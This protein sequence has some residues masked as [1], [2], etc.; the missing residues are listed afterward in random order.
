MSVL[1]NIFFFIIAIGVLVTFHEFGHY[2][3]ARKS[4]VK[5]L[6]FSIGFGR[7]LISWTRTTK[8]GDEIEFVIAAIPLGGYVRM[9]DE[10]EG[11][12]DE[13]DK[14][15][16]FNNQSVLTRIAIVAAGPVFNFILAVVFYWAV[17]LLGST[18]DRPLVGELDTGSVAADA[19]FEVRDEVLSVSGQPVKSWND[20]R[21][22]ILDEGLDGGNLT[23]RVL[24]Q[25]GFEIDRTLRLGDIHLL[26]EEGDVIGRLG[27][28]QWWPQ[29]R[30]EIG[31]VVADSPAQKGGLR[32]GDVVVRVDGIPVP[33]WTD[34]VEQI[35]QKPEQVMAFEVERNG[36]LVNLSVT[37]GTRIVK[38]SS[39]GFVGAYQHIPDSVRNDLVRRVE[40]GPVEAL[41]K[42]GEKT[43]DMSVLTLR[44]LW[45]MV[46]GEAALANISGPITIASYAGVTAAIGLV[47]Y[48]SFLAV[49][50]VSLGVLNL[51]PVPMLDGG[52]LFYYLI[53]IIKGSPVSQ[54][55]EL[56]GQQVGML[57]LALLMSVAIFNDIQRL[58][59]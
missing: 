12:V 55:F 3:V 36:E 49:I 5:V 16:A 29:L 58:I 2:W 24:T 59:Q 42:A 33:L 8:E 6:R 52:H 35:Q 40:Y 26:A 32:E 20:F 7:A 57:I 15:R 53:E 34:L 41:V 46:S 22:A 39:Q 50:S 44:V 1:H 13:A 21:L 17:F 14:P 30:A 28:H 43:W 47:S 51:L 31:G 18:V 37:P 4:G 48:L 11:D 38:D 45:K 10:R 25:S 54:S 23:V 27:F 9:L 19:G 56:R